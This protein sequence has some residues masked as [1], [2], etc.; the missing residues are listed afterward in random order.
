MFSIFGFTA[1]MDFHSWAPLFEQC[2]RTIGLAFLSLPQHQFLVDTYPFSL[3]SL[4]YFSTTWV[5]VYGLKDK[6]LNED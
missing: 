6:L 4:F 5:L 1:L 2:K 3:E